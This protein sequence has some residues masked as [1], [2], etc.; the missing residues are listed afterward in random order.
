MSDSQETLYKCEECSSEFKMRKNLYAHMRKVHELDIHVS[1]KGKGSELCPQCGIAFMRCS[2]LKRHQITVH[3]MKSEENSRKCRIICPQCSLSFLTYDTL[4]T[5]IQENHDVSFECQ[6]IEFG[7]LADFEEWKISYEKVNHVRYVMNCSEQE[8]LEKRVRYYH[9]HRSFNFNS[10]G[11]GARCV[12]SMGTN[13]IGSTCPSNMQVTITEDKCCLKFFPKHMGHTQDV[14]R[15]F[16]HRNE[17]AELAGRLSQG[18]P[19]GRVL[20]DV[21]SAPIAASVER[22]HLLEKKDLHNIKRDFDIGYATKKHEND[23]VSVKLW[24]EEMKRQSDNPVLYFK[25]QKQV[26][27]NFQDEDFILIIMTDFQAEQLLKYGEDK[28]CVDGTHGMTAYDFQLFTIVVVDRLVL[29]C[30]LHFVFQIGE[31]S[32]YNAWSAVMGPVPNQLLCSWH[33]QRNWSQN[34]R[35]ISEGSEKKSAVFSSLKRL[36]T[37]LDIDVFSCSLEKVVENLLNDPDTAE[38]GRYF[39]K[40]YC[41]RVEKWAYCFRHRLGINTNNYLESLHKVIKYSYLEGKKCRRLD[42]SLNALLCLVRDKVYEGLVKL[43]K[44]KQCSRASR[45]KASHNDSSAITNGMIL[46]RGEGLWEVLSSTGCEV[47]VVVKN[48]EL[49][50]ERKCSLKCNTCNICVHSYK[51][52]C[53]DNILNFNICKHI[54]ACAKSLS[55][56]VQESEQC[57]LPSSADN[58][59]VSALLSG[60]SEKSADTFEQDVMSHCETIVALSKGTQCGQETKAKVLKDLKKIIGNLNKDFSFSQENTV[61]VNAKIESQAR[62]F[63][64]KRRRIL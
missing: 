50:C 20:Q 7:C 27:P 63:S 57:S 5:H 34:L 44:R 64:T 23:A 15:T 51:C 18:V 43:S 10:K 32:F 47:Y 48:S 29:E 56:A 11:T 26:D 53:L 41:Q 3:G 33:I 16:L 9:C 59:Y 54:H 28:I 42:K 40:M 49:T 31:T 30:Q 13:K 60:N 6:E 39:L 38:F 45:V 25:Q 14:G 22:I 36:Q 52:S 24:V 8:R 55:G 61:N 46:C 4:R 12:K 19:V 1:K 21:L 58:E 62:F 17:R 2:S 37:E 35:R